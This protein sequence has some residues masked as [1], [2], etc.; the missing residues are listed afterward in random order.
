MSLPLAKI[1]VLDLSRALCGPFR[2]MILGDPGA[3]LA[4]PTQPLWASV[5]RVPREGIVATAAGKN[6]P[7]AR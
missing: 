4:A 7:C 6:S 1:R 5:C 3:D 2:S